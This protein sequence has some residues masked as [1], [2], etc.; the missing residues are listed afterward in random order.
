MEAL[1]DMYLKICS[2]HGARDDCHLY[3]MKAFFDFA[4]ALGSAFSIKSCLE[5]L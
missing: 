5:T 1:L 3:S 2:F 4:N